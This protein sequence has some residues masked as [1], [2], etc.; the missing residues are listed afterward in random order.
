MEFKNKLHSNSSI[1]S[2]NT[3]INSLLRLPSDK[4]K[5][6]RKS[7]L[8]KSI[9][10]WNTVDVDIRNINSITVFKKKIKILLIENKI[11]LINCN[12]AMNLPYTTAFYIQ[13]L[14][15]IFFPLIFMFYLCVLMLLFHL[16]RT[17]TYS[18]KGHKCLNYFYSISLCPIFCVQMLLFHL[19][20]SETYSNK[21]HKSPF[22]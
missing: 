12:F 17:E 6:I 22:L 14:L 4:Q 16:L 8:C 9:E 18:N 11:Q 21:G 2:Y 3:R 13:R 15:F 20:R 1:H 10:L 19:M 7:Y 5:L